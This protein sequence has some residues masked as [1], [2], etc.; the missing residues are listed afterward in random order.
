MISDEEKIRTE[1]LILEVDENIKKY[2][3][4][5][6]SDHNEWQ[7]IET[8]PKDGTHVLG[9]D[10]F[11]NRIYECCMM[12]SRNEGFFS[13]LYQNSA[14]YEITHWM[15]LPQKPKKKHD[16]KRGSVR[17]YETISGY[18]EIHEEREK[19]GWFLVTYCEFCP[20]CGEKAYVGKAD[21]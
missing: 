14:Q 19:D 13:V 21:G 6:D 5:I 3:S 10:K 8:V 15:P 1:K 4:S 11:N 17:L 20:F 9:Y 2:K 18:Y 16:C 7:P 12:A